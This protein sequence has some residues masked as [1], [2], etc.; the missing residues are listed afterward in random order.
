[1]ERGKKGPELDRHE[2]H[3]A[4]LRK[5]DKRIEAKGEIIWPCV[6]SLASHYM[7][8]LK[9]LFEAFGRPFD[10]ED[11][12]KLRVVVEDKLR[13][14][15]ASG[16]FAR[17]QVEYVTDP[18]PGG[19]LDYTVTPLLSS[20]DD[21]YATWVAT[22]TPPL[23]GAHADA[24]VLDVARSFGVPGRTTV[25]DAGA[26]TGRNTLPLARAG[27]V[28]DA[29]EPAAALV[30]VLRRS[31]EE[32]RLE[33][34]VVHGD[35]LDDAVDLGKGRYQLI[36]LA[37]VVASHF[38]DVGEVRRLFERAA[39]LLA[40]N[41][42]LLLNAFIAVDPYK[43]EVE[44]REFSHTAWSC[45]FTRPELAS[46]VQGLPLALSSD[47]SVYDYEKAHLAP[48]AWPPTGWFEDWTRG[49]DVFGLPEGR[50]PIELRWLAYRRR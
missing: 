31:V 20:M 5:L 29:L 33:V 14:G 12:A 44:A 10:K 43:P 39:H 15:W 1:M 28:T 42:M 37:E 2:L 32:E 25:L 8:A 26:G 48:S 13:E 35:V 11:L 22:R 16:P 24:K 17:L 36:V 47:E 34:R 9:T 45:I 40:P 27:Y 46:A 30:E 50:A 18:R 6:P 41:G 3:R 38:H 21:V 49:F 19:G 4:V 23:F 7:R